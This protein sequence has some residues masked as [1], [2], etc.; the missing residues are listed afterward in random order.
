MNNTLK[1]I[2]A[3]MA[4]MLVNV[5][6][7]VASD[8]ILESTGIFTPPDA[9]FFTPWMLAVALAYRSVYTVAGGYATAALAPT[10][11]MRHVIILG[12]IGAVLSAIGTVVAWDLSS[13][14][15]PIALLVIAMPLTYL[16]GKMKI[17][18]I[19]TK[20]SPS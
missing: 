7:S 5:I 1:S 19:Q 13:H 11:P 20:T 14:W 16:G 4:G 9:G 12:S 6:L 2:W 10:Q 15:Y 8:F 18:S 3:V 17:N